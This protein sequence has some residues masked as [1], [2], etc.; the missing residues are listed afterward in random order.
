MNSPCFC[1]RLAKRS[2]IHTGRELIRAIKSSTEPSLGASVG[3]ATFGGLEEAVAEDVIVRADIALYQAK[4]RPG[5]ATAWS[6]QKIDR[7]T[8]VETIR[9]AIRDDRILVYSQPIL[10]LRSNRIEGEELLVRLISPDG[11]VIPPGAFLPTAERYG[12]AQD[13]DRL[14]MNRALE[15]ARSGRRIAVNVS[16]RD[17]RRRA[18]LAARRSE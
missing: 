17:Q 2:A 14:V 8:W 11:E 9:D 5:S 6:G 15:L 3:L 1:R 4:Q 10:S 13:I 7:L 16:A 18:D 12:L